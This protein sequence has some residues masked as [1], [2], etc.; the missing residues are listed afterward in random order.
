[1]PFQSQAQR[2]LCWYKYTQAKK[3]GKEPEWDCAQWE[4]ETP[5]GPKDSPLPERKTLKKS[6]KTKKARQSSERRPVKRGSKKT[7]KRKVKKSS[8]KKGSRK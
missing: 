6:S 8:K 2:K 1:M 7:S 4:R 3:A 5:K